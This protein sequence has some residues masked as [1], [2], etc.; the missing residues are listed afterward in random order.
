[1]VVLATLPLAINDHTSG[2]T[3]YDDSWSPVIGLVIS[4]WLVLIGIGIQ[5]R[6][7]AV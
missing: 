1:V 3:R 2:D 5:A 4:L 6:R 7:V